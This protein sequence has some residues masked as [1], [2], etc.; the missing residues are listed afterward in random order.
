MNVTHRLISVL[1]VLGLAG[2]MREADPWASIEGTWQPVGTR[3]ATADK[4]TLQ[5]QLDG[6]RL[7]MTSSAGRGYTAELGGGE[8]ELE[9]APPGTTVAVNQS[10]AVAYREIV[11]RNGKPVSARIVA[12]MD[13][14]MITVFENRLD[15]SADVHVAVKR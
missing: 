6:D 15:G 10:S 13:N 3:A 9:G 8:V 2:C 7:R 14:K 12:V 11:M 4:P 5:Y 1:L